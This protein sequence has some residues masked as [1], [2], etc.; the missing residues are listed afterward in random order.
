MHLTNAVQN[1]EVSN[2]YDSRRRAYSYYVASYVRVWTCG[3]ERLQCH[4]R[5]TTRDFVIAADVCEAC[6]GYFTDG[7]S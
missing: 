7:L 6:L 2:V 5:G 4:R 3:I 1:L